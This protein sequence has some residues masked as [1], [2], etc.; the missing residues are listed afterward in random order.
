MEPDAEERRGP[1][2]RATGGDSDSD[3]PRPRLP[4]FEV[5]FD[6]RVCTLLVVAAGEI[7]VGGICNDIYK[8]DPYDSKF[9]INGRTDSEAAPRRAT[10][11]SRSRPSTLLS[12]SAIYKLTGRRS[13]Q[14]GRLPALPAKSDG[15]NAR[16][17][18]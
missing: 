12:T 6:L 10:F 5:A 17:R 8:T 13:C 2:C 3:H 1:I 11:D 4:V 7:E 18:N 9:R 16:L 14:S 15:N